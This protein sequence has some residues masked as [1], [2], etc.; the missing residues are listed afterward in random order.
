MA[1]ELRF[2]VTI[3][4]VGNVLPG[5]QSWMLVGVQITL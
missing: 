4:D 1:C 5:L 3:E 2:R